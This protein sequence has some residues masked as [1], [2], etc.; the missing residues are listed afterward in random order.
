MYP[1][2]PPPNS[3][4]T[5]S[6]YGG[7]REYERGYERESYQREAEYDSYEQ[8]SA[9]LPRGAPAYVQVV[10]GSVKGAS[11]SPRHHPYALPGRGPPPT[12]SNVRRASGRRRASVTSVSSGSEGSRSP[13]VRSATLRGEGG[14]GWE[15]YGGEVG[16]EGVYRSP[17]VVVGEARAGN[18]VHSDT[19]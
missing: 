11:V 18:F 17:Y 3:S 2:P 13:V 7:E 16:R 12:T 1:P 19:I 9:P 8:H 5:P 14:E 15:G 4:S 6:G 10:S